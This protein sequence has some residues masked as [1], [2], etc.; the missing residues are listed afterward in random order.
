M[1]HPY[2]IYIWQPSR[3]PNEAGDWIEPVQ[4]YTQEYALYI[5]NL[6]HNDT[7]SVMKV[8]R[9]GHTIAAYPN[10]ETVERI[11]VHIAKWKPKQQ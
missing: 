1:T 5:A 11:E 3:K 9:Y 8:V 6:I 10:A 4:A 7:K 2:S